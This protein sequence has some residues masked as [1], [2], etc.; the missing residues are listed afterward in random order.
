VRLR[1]PLVREALLAAA[2]AG[3][4]AALL[5]WLGPPGADF[6]AH[7]YQRT[8]FLDHGFTLWNNFWYAGRYSFVTYSVIYY[9]LAAFLGIRLL[10]VATI[11]LAALAFAVVLWR[12]WG[13]TTRWSS[14]TF[15]VIWAGIV[16]SAAFPFALG[17]AFALLAIWALQWG[18][19]WR[20][21]ALAGLTLAA[22]PLAFLLLVV[23]L[24][25]V[26]LARRDALQRNWVP[27]AGVVIAALLE[28]ALWR[29]FPAGGRFPFTW[30]EFAAGVVFCGGCLAMTWTVPHARVLRFMFAV[31]LAAVVTTFVVPSAIG[32]NVMRLRY[33][34]VPIV[35]LV[36]ALRRWRPRAIGIVGVSLALSWNLTPFIWSWVHSSGDATANAATWSSAIGFL[37]ANLEPSYRVEAVDTSTHSASMYLAEAGIPLARGWYRQDDF[38]QNEVLYDDL[39]AAAYLRWLHGLGVKYVV[40]ARAAPDYSSRAEADIVRSGRAGLVIALATPELTVYEVPHARA[41]VTGP[42]HPRLTSLGEARIG[43]QLTAAGTYRIAVRW[44]PYW[45]ASLGCLSKGSDGMLRLTTRHPHFVRLTFRLSATRALEEFAGEQPRCTLP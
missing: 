17:M 32:E 7:A 18:K 38:P 45:H 43:V 35:V 33:A 30:A 34:A 25:G 42:G 1:H 10:A 44:S 15:A 29:V 11:A 6:A 8:V 2:I 40:L 5:V 12:E 3:S 14:R 4:T 13:P 9:P 24:G 37:R 16:L 22:S 39:G 20:F 26:A 21:A 31:Y 36:F 28:L 27:I 41:I 23:V 19:R